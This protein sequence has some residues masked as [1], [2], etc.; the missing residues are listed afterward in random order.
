MSLKI[1][2]ESLTKCLYL[3]L[4][5]SYGFFA[6][7][8]L[9]RLNLLGSGDIHNYIDFFSYWDL[10]L[11]KENF[12]IVADGVFRILVVYLIAVLNYDAY[13]VLTL[14]AF[15]TSSVFLFISLENIRSRNR[16]IYLFPLLILV[17]FTPFITNLFVSGIRS[18][19]AFTIVMAAIL[20][21]EKVTKNILFALGCI[22]HLSM[23]PI[24][25]LTI[26]FKI[27]DKIKIK[28]SFRFFISIIF[29]LLVVLIAKFLDFTSPISQSFLYNMLIFYFA[30]LI[31]FI[32]K[33]AFTNFYG[34]ISISLVLIYLMGITIDVS[35]IRYF[36]YSILFYLFYLMKEGQKEK[37]QIFTIG[38]LP[39][40]ALLGFYTVYNFM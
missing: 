18:G 31:I 2:R 15:I 38:Y 22:I 20:Y 34:F 7:A 24:V 5:L 6:I 28:S 35:F 21:F 40:F 1:K 8:S 25:G 32:D 36:G 37:I 12:S 9:E 3:L 29:S 30:L 23:I 11:A 19:I 10:T 13:E 27:L 17:F 14:L 4:S 39:I 26:L 16:S 33:E